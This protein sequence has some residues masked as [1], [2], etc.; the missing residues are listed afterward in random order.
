MVANPIAV[1]TGNIATGV[2]KGKK[3]TVFS[4]VCG[5]TAVSFG[6]ASYPEAIGSLIIVNGIGAASV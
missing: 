4:A 3:I 6:I 2:C 5:G 1:G